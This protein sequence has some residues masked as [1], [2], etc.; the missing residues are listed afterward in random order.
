MYYV[1]KIFNSFSRHMA[2]IWTYF[3]SNNE[4][5]EFGKPYTMI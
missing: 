3:N 1:L 5:S 4:N 2:K